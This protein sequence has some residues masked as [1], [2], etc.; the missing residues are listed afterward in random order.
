MSFLLKIVEGPNKGAEIALVEGVAVT[1]GKADDC[2]IVLADA[3]LPDAPFRVAATPTGVTLDGSQI[4][5]FHVV[6]AGSTAF[7]VGPSDG[8]W[9]EL[10]W[11]Q[12]ET[13]SVETG[14]GKEAE[15][16]GEP[17]REESSG[18]SRPPSEP[19]PEAAPK[20]RRGCLGCLIIAI[21]LLL[22]LLGLAWFFRDAL[23]PRVEAL[24][25]RGSATTTEKTAESDKKVD[26][27]ADPVA[28]ALSAIASKYGLSITNAEGRLGLAGNLRTRAERLAATAEAYGVQP[29][30]GLDLSDDESFRTAAEDALFM[31]TEGAL[32]VVSATNRFLSIRGKSA[33]PASLKRTLL[34][35]NEDLSK[36]RDVDVSA[37]AFGGIAACGPVA[38]GGA[39]DPVSVA[40]APPPPSPPR[41]APRRVAKP[42][43]NPT[44]PVC[45]ILTTPYPCLVMKNGQRIL[46]GAMVGDST[47]LK[48]SADSV[49]V[50]NSSG[51]FVWKP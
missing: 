8:A 43:S 7:A 30:V 39:A 9:G 20:R 46:E 13:G 47:I 18:D 41:A 26:V 3:T 10:V 15:T 6:S 2:D 29:G 33:S 1:L 45:G 49:V 21:V 28:G 17:P 50:T 14:S 51:R 36:L 34:A 24:W 11:P 5:P 32:K 12:R 25:K 44:F 23:R 19:A 35:L 27:P 22:L 31:L 48:I 38:T 16:A 4:E 40:V 42:A 37:V